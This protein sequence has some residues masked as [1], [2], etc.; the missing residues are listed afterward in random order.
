MSDGKEC[1]C[2]ARCEAECACDADWTPEEIYQ[3]RAENQALKD[4][5]NRMRVAGGSQE[6]QAA[7]D[8]AK[9]LL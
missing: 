6:F 1:Q 7:F 5:I 3:L 2:A 9:G 4:A 8:F